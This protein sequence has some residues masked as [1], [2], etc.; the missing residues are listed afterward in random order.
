MHLCDGPMNRVIFDSDWE[1]VILSRDIAL[2]ALLVYSDSLTLLF[3]FN[4]LH[5]I[6]KLAMFYH[7][8]TGHVMLYDMMC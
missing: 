6:F 8:M 5:I 3:C 2:L 7:V 4:M 1:N